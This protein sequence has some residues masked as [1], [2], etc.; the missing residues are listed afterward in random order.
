M[1]QKDKDNWFGRD[2]IIVIHEYDPDTG[3]IRQ[4]HDKN[5][6]LIY[7]FLR[8]LGYKQKK[9]TSQSAIIKYCD[10]NKRDMC[11]RESISGC[12][13]C[14]HYVSKQEKANATR[15]NG[16]GDDYRDVIY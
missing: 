1:R 5:I 7:N 12:N 15:R 11:Q 3:I 9:S 2:E 16:L 6:E 4:D 10:F 8:K 14:R 13:D